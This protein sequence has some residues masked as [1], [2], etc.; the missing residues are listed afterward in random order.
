MKSLLVSTCCVDIK[1]V[2]ALEIWDPERKV[3][4]LARSRVQTVGKLGHFGL[5][6]GGLPKPKWVWGVLSI[7]KGGSAKCH[8]NYY[9]RGWFPSSFPLGAMVSPGEL[10]L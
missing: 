3:T 5:E 8:I 2:F 4:P 6:M 9:R 7:Y 10:K 1:S